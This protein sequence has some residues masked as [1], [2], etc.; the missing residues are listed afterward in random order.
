MVAVGRAGVSPGLLLLLCAAAGP[1]RCWDQ[2]GRVLLREVRALT[3]RR[4][5]HTASRRTP[6]VPQLQCTGGT[7]GCSRTPEVV[8]C[9]N[10]GW[11]GYDVQ[12]ECK[13]DLENT[14]RF[15]QMEVSCEGYD[16]PDDPYIL[17]G[18]CSLLFRL[19]L[20]EE[21]ERKVKNSGSFGSSYYQSRKESSDSG[22]GAIVIIVLLV[23]A[24]GVY[25]LFLGNQQPQTQSFGGSDGFTRPSWQS[26]QTPPPPGFKSTFTEDNSFGTHSSP[27]TD[28]GPGFWTGL[29]AGGLLGY[30]AGSHRA[31]PR[32]P[33]C[34]MWTDPA[35]APPMNGQSSN[36]TQSSSS[37]TR[38]ASGFGGTKRR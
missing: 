37:G 15:G 7:A 16:Y 3:L 24:F 36:S 34:S 32:S 9:Y 14:D 29:G 21:G 1:A 31:Q 12:W 2:P 13:A 25:K 20:T 4:G 35:A 27:G 26:Q 17:R 18:S 19:E 23:L 11:D 6:A 38:T 30:L 8:Q 5:Q 28:S 33:Y 10:K 22:A